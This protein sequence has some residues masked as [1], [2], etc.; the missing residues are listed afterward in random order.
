MAEGLAV[1]VVATVLVIGAG[2][3]GTLAG[4]AALRDGA[5]SVVCT[6]ALALYLT[7]V[8]A[9]RALVGAVVLTSMALS[10]LTPRVTAE[11]ALTERGHRQDVLV[12]AVLAEQPSLGRSSTPRCSYAWQ[13]GKPVSVA[14]RRACRATTAVGER[15][16]VMVDPKGVLSPR[17]VGHFR[18]G[19][20]WV[21]VGLALLFPLLCFVAVQR[22]YGLTLVAKR[23]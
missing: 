15:I 14:I 13:N 10:V 4:P 18:L 3:Y 6:L 23:Q 12:T 20:L 8:R 16:T 2:V 7:F 5:G 17:A 11:I 19:R 21:T 22:S 1:A 9:N